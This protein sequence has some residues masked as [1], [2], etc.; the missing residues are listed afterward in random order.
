M[1]FTDTDTASGSERAS[2]PDGALAGAGPE[3]REP[4]ERE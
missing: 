4:E 3:A 2:G 1:I